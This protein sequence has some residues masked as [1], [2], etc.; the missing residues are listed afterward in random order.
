M[1]R[2]GAAE[3]TRLA[4]WDGSR[5]DRPL[6]S[7]DQVR[8]YNKILTKLKEAPMHYQQSEV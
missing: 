6:G 3:A 5:K 7:L 8:D 1:T 2:P 4:G